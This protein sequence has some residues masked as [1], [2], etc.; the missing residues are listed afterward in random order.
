MRILNSKFLWT[1]FVV[2]FGISFLFA[3]FMEVFAYIS[4]AFLL[5]T[6]VHRSGF[7]I[8][9]LLLYSYIIEPILAYK[10]PLG[11]GDY[12]PITSIGN[13]IQIPN[14]RLM[15]IFGIEFQEY[16]GFQDIFISGIWILVFHSIIYIYYQ[17]R[18]F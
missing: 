12:L 2:V 1:L 3:Y 13:I 6:V 11:W 4:F 15:R 18:D 10:L 9:I 14:S 16:I 8:G 5:A 17:K 7:A